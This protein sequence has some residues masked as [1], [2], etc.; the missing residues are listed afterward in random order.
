LNDIKQYL[1]GSIIDDE[2]IKVSFYHKH[3]HTVLNM[4]VKATKD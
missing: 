1:K 2:T 3:T 4:D